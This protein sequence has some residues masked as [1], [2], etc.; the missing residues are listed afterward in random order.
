MTF[1]RGVHAVHGRLNGR[2]RLESR[3]RRAL[4]LGP[5]Y[6]ADQGISWYPVGTSRRESST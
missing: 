2:R 1:R 3:H 4:H 6:F 5:R